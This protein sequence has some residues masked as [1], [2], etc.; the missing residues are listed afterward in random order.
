MINEGEVIAKGRITVKRPRGRPKRK[1]KF[2][3]LA[4]RFYYKYRQTLSSADAFLRTANILKTTEASVRKAV[5]ARRNSE[6]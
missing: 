3:A 5:T 1:H 6:K 2:D 4:V